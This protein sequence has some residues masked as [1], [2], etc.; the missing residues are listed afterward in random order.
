MANAKSL[1]PSLLSVSCVGALR[2]RAKPT[3]CGDVACS[4]AMHDV[5]DFRAYTYP[6]DVL[7]ADGHTPVNRCFDS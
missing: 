7:V 2:R 5:V 6:G 4:V 1:V 3:N